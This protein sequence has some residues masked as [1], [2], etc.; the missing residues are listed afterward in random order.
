MNAE[1]R[2][3]P[4]AE[5]PRYADGRPVH[6][7]RFGTAFYVDWQRHGEHTCLWYEYGLA[8]HVRCKVCGKVKRRG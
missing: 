1:P 6:I 7:V 3:I 5:W 8:D 2:V 4:M